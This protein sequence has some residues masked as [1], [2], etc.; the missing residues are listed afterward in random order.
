MKTTVETES[1][2]KR[3]LLIEVT[4]DELAPHYEATLKRLANELKVPGFRKGKVLKAVLESRVGKDTIREEVLRDALPALYARAADAESLDPVTY[5]DIEVTKFEQGG[6]LTFTARLEV[7]PIFELPDYTGIEVTRP[8]H[9]PSEDEVQQQLER[10][11]EQFGTLESVG[12]NAIEGDHLTINLSCSIHGEKLDEASA[13]ALIYELGSSSLVPKLDIELMGKRPGD[14]L[15]FNDL[16]PAGMGA[17]GGQEAT[18]TVV[19]KEVQT[20][21]LPVLDDEFAKSASEFDTLD[22]LTKAVRDRVAGFKEVEANL[23]VRS[24]AIRELV[25][26]TDVSVP[27]ALV[28]SETQARLSD[29]LIQLENGNA[30]FEQYL[31]ANQTTKEALLEE[32]RKEAEQACAARLVLEEVARREDIKVTKEDLAEYLVAHASRLDKEPGEFAKE[33]EKAGQ[34]NAMAGDILRRKAADLVVEKA[35]IIDAAEPTQNLED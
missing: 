25:T 20:K 4:P 12:R 32:V 15:K 27:E 17:H 34:M 22:E 3:T 30:T 35:S 14:I 5:P 1:P 26:R 7:R 6:P 9:E 21:N 8:E 23:V 11:R 2:T 24:R 13:D 18:F 29:L 19:V 16:L 33:V 28:A 31:E 10:I